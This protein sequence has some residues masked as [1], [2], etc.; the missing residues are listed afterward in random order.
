[1]IEYMKFISRDYIRANPDKYFIV[2]DNDSR[3]GSGGQAK[4]MRGEANSI[5]IRVKKTAGT[6]KSA[7]YTDSEY[8]DNVTKIVQDFAT[9]NYYLKKGKTV[10]VPSDGIGTGLAKLKD[11]APYTLKFVKDIIK[12]LEKHNEIK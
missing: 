1:M 8:L 11:Y 9:V 3:I 5:G 12:T 4:E 10:V 6:N 2:G 7:Y